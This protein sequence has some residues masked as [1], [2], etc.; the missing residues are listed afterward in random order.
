[1][2]LP[3]KTAISFLDRQHP[4]TL[5]GFNRVYGAETDSSRYENLKSDRQA[6]G[7][8]VTLLNQLQIGE[9][10]PART[11]ILIKNNL[12][13]TPFVKASLTN[14]L[15]DLR[16]RLVLSEN[17]FQRLHFQINGN[18]FEAV[19]SSLYAVLLYSKLAEAHDLATLNSAFHF[20]SSQ[21]YSDRL[22]ELNSFQQ[23]QEFKKLEKQFQK[24]KLEQLLLKLTS[25]EGIDPTIP[26]GSTALFVHLHKSSPAVFKEE[27]TRYLET[28]STS[29]SPFEQ[30]NIGELLKEVRETAPEQIIGQSYASLATEE[31][32]KQCVRSINILSQTLE[33]SSRDELIASMPKCKSAYNGSLYLL[34]DFK[35]LPPISPTRFHQRTGQLKTQWEKI[36]NTITRAT[37]QPAH[38][39]CSCQT[40]LSPSQNGLAEWPHHSKSLI[41]LTPAE[42]GAIN[43]PASPTLI[44]PMTRQ[45]NQQKIIAVIGCHWGGGHSAVTQ[46]VIS[47]LAKFGYHTHT[48]DLP[49]VLVSEDPVRN[50]FLTR[51]LG[52]DW[53]VDFLFNSLLRK[54]AHACINFLRSLSR[55][56][57]DPEGH[58]RKLTLTLNQLLTSNP[59]MV[60][61]TYS[62]HNEPIF[63]AC[64]LLGIPC[65]HIS[66]DIDTSVETRTAPRETSHEKMMIAFDDPDMIRR[67]ETTTRPDQLVIGGPPVRHEFT[68]PRTR[69]DAIYLKQ[70]WGIDPKKKVIVIANGKNGTHSRYP[71]ILAKRYANIDPQD[72]PFH[73]V[74][75]CGS[76]NRSFLNELEQNV[77]PSTNLPMSLFTSVP[78]Q[79]MEEMITMAAHGG[80]VVGKAG[81]STLFE[82]IA[83]GTRMLIDNTEPPI[84]SMGITH[85]IFFI[86]E[87]ILRKFGYK[88]QLPWEE[89]NAT[90][91][92]GNGFAD[93]FRTEDEFL[94]KLDRLT[95]HEDPAPMPFIVRNCEEVLLQTVSSMLFAAETDRD[96]VRIRQKIRAI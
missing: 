57:P 84:F 77:I 79:Q 70:Q 47:N 5:D 3:H 44:N 86:F 81:G 6:T 43:T 35:N 80:C 65:L 12:H 82:S 68:I 78:G 7:P 61:T 30:L 42:I 56:G 38:Q 2:A 28:L 4:I 59:D 69:E 92:L 87:W 31:H 54:K 14:L 50:F 67:V 23:R 22:I 9:L 55:G 53:T 93:S 89:I 10:I 13:D 34:H 85:A 11:A 45:Q 63:D 18:A 20:Q 73:L 26:G 75:L 83:R 62:A 94:N 15:F 60:I 74:V 96:M 49:K 90:F 52:K 17:F 29:A 40:A 39:L 19:L 88:D 24:K 46:G 48:I 91:A 16:S 33:L 95:D 8:L 64:R 36:N 71:K 37:G 66:T 27:L 32:L 58:Q 21:D 41:Q 51:W 72:I 1:M 25:H 76:N